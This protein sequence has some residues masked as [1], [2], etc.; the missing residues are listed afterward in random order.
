MAEASR[1]KFMVRVNRCD[2]DTEDHSMM[3]GT[4]IQ[5]TLDFA[6]RKSSRT[7]SKP[8]PFQLYT[9]ECWTPKKRA[10]N[11]VS[12]TP[13][14]RSSKRLREPD[15]EGCSP[16]KRRAAE[17]TILSPKI[18][19]SKPERIPLSPQK[20]C[21]NVQTV[22]TF[23]VL[24][25]PQKNIVKIDCCTPRSCPVISPSRVRALHFSPVRDENTFTAR[26]ALT[27]T[28]PRRRCPYGTVS[29]SAKNIRSPRKQLE[30]GDSGVSRSPSKYARQ[31]G[32]CYQRAKQALHTSLPEKIVGREEES[33]Q[34]NKFLEE[35]LLGRRPGSL[36][37]SGAPGTGK[38]AV[39]S[40]IIK[41]YME[42]RLCQVI[43][44]NCMSL[45]NA[46]AIYN[47]VLSDLK[48]K[49]VCL[50]ARQAAQ[51][52]ETSLSTC[53]SMV[54][55]VLDEIDQLDSKNQEVLY[56]MFEWP[57]LAHSKL[58][59]IGIANALDL[60][61]R[62]LPRLQARPTCKPQLL[63]FSPYSREQ[64]VHILQDR[65]ENVVINGENVMEPSAIQ[66]CARKVAALAGDMRKALDVC[67]SAVEMVEA[68]VRRKQ[69][70]LSPSKRSV[71]PKV[72]VAH[73]MKIVNRTYGSVAQTDQQQTFPLQQ[74]LAVC[75][76]L[77]MLRH[78]KTKEVAVGKL[79]ESYCKVC[80]A[81]N[82]AAVDQS[83][84]SSMCD[85]IEARSIIGLKKAKDARMVKV[86]LKLDE[87]ELDFALQDKTLMSS[88][89]SRG[90]PK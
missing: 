74:K 86:A 16:F 3:S 28:T 24:K 77:L 69:A 47:K 71:M 84:F 40:E 8:E 30:W 81:Q 80:K 42:S 52:L 58:V 7:R 32:V 2:R 78:G 4:Q 50:P 11:D 90:L 10:K 18:F 72:G 1:T 12:Q 60:T 36:Y 62:V 6:V 41:V 85:L 21:S 57:A 25:T 46:H 22:S 64:I 82:V 67:R 19:L 65:L 31:H 79:H 43:S 44:A 26:R 20:N 55:L 15:C 83:E 56:T 68:D 37:V 49:N 35:H 66:F 13:R 34:V 87:Q 51:Q 88:I 48:K 39:L 29:P 54:L 89:L 27:L 23:T 45:Q 5:T 9:D 33:R 70:L 14:T 38:T 59:L 17:N 53:K 76:L 75:T 63:H 73:I 61:D